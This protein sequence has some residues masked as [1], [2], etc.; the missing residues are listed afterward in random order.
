MGRMSE[1]PSA[2]VTSGVVELAA[3][4]LSGWA[5]T[6]A[7]SN[8]QGAR[9]AGVAS[10]PRIRQWHL[11][12]VALGTSTVALGVAVPDAPRVV[13]GSLATGAWTNAMLFLPLAFKPELVDEPGYK[14]AAGASFVATTVGFVG[15][16]ATAIARRRAAR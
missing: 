14:A 10:V 2:L 1:R 13:Q 5:F 9:R 7:I 4:A 8:P 15:M 11:D 12:L 16:A 6:Y 3:A